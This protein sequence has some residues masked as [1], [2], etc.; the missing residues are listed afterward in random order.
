MVPAASSGIAQ[1]C[2]AAAVFSHAFPSHPVYALS[3]QTVQ[4]QD[5]TATMYAGGLLL[6]V[7]PSAAGTAVQQLQEAGFAAACVIGEVLQ[8]EAAG[9]LHVVL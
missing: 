8:A 5:S 4:E 9:K 6:G 2:T 1:F 7:D 3:R